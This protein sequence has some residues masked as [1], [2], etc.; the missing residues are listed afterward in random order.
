MYNQLRGRLELW[1]LI[2]LQRHKVIHL[3]RGN[4]LEQLVSSRTAAIT[5]VY[6]SKESMPIVKISLHESSLL[7]EIRKNKSRIDNYRKLI[8]LTGIPYIEV[9]YE[10]LLLKRNAEL[11]RVAS[12]LDSK[13]GQYEDLS[14]LK[15]I[16]TYT[17]KERLE[18]YDNIAS[19]LKGTEFEV[20]L[21]DI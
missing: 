15:K 11:N 3:I 12:F 17:L 14:A 2:V 8:K 13:I 21:D 4:I 6:Q 18:N 19:L 20:F 16:N 5:G 10:N 7:A 1:L 9:S